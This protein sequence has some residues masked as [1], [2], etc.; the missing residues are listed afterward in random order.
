MTRP[1]PFTLPDQAGKPWSLSKHRGTPVVLYFAERSPSRG[2]ED[3]RARRRTPVGSARSRMMLLQPG[4][5]KRCACRSCRR[6]SSFRRSCRRCSRRP[7]RRTTRRRS[8]LR[9]ATST[10]LAFARWRGRHRRTFVTCCKGSPFRPCSCTQ[11]RTSVHRARCGAPPCRDRG[12]TARGP[13]RRRPRLQH[14]GCQPVQRRGPSV[15]RRP[16]LVTTPYR[17]PMPLDLLLLLSGARR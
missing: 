1:P 17:R 16:R 6:T 3:A 5:S 13:A 12:I 2:P 4:S 9:C 10:R 7:S 15:P 14:R 8:A 11:T